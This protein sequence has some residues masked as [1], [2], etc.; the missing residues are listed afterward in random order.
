MNP[1]LFLVVAFIF[2]ISFAVSRINEARHDVREPPNLPSN[3]PFIGHV[4]GMLR[5]K[6]R[7]YIWLR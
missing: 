2:A 6:V 4:I 3:V 1:T 5:M 7:Y